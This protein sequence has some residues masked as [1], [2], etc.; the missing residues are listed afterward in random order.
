MSVSKSKK[1]TS[2]EIRFVA[3]FFLFAVGLTYLLRLSWIDKHAV[4]PYT[5]FLARIIVRISNFFGLGAESHRTMIWRGS[6]GIEIR[7]GCDGIEATLLLVAACLAYPFTWA[8]RILGVLYGFSLIFVL[9]LIR[10]VALFYLG[11]KGSEQ[12]FNFVHIYVSQFVVIALTMVFFIF[13]AGRER[14]IRP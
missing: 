13:W 3:L 5:E 8:S 2:T 11:L 7:R 6:F 14:T 1:I 9:N 4:E 12:T 10:T